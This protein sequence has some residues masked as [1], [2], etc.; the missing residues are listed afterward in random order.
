MKKTLVALLAVAAAWGCTHEEPV[1]PVPSND[2]Y[3]SVSTPDDDA[4]VPG[5]I[6][7]KLTDDAEA[8]RTGVFT[9]GAV[10]SGNEK[11][12]EIA[13]Q[14]GATEIRRV[15]RDG[16]KYA[17]RRRKY[18]LHLWYD[19]KLGEDV[20]VSRAEAGMRALPGVRYAIPLY[21]LVSDEASIV[22]EMAVELRYQPVMTTAIDAVRP[23]VEPPFNDEY[24]D[25]QWHYYNTGTIEGT[26]EGADV[27]LYAA[28]EEE[29]GDPSVIVAV[30]D[31]G[32]DVDH[33]DLAAN[34]WINPG[35][36]PGNGIDDDGNGYVDDVYGYNFVSDSGDIVDY[37]HGTHVA[38]TIA[39]V[40]NNGVGVCGVAGGTG[41]GDGARIMSV[42]W[43]ANND[44]AIP[45]IDRFAYAA[46]NGAVIASCSWE[47]ASPD[48]APDLL[49]GL[50]YFIDM[51]GMDEAGVSQVGPVKGGVVIFA[52]GNSNKNDLAYPVY[53]DRVVSVAAMAAN[54]AKTSY[55][56]YSPKVSILAPGGEDS[57]Q[58]LGIYSTFAD[59][60]YG[61]K[62]GT[63]MATP[64][65]SG[66][67]ALIASKYGGMGF[68]ADQLK[69]K[70]LASVRPISPVVEEQYANQI[71]VGLVDAGMAV[72][73]MSNPQ[74][75][76]AALEEYGVM[77]RPD[78]LVIYCKVPA[79]GNGMPVTKYLLQYAEKKDGVTGEWHDM[80]LI[81][82]EDVGQ[83]YEYGFELV[84]LTTYALKMKAVDRW[85]NEGEEVSFEGTT[86]KHT[87]RPPVQ[88]ARLLDL[89]IASA[90]E[91]NIKRFRMENYFSDPDVAYG[92]ALSFT[93]TSSDPSV[94]EATIDAESVL[95]ILPLKA[96][97]SIITVR[98]LDTEG[99]YL[100][101]SFDVTVESG[102]WNH[103]P[104]VTKELGAVE[105]ERVGDQLT[106]A[107]SE[108]FSD[109]DIEAGDKL[110]YRILATEGNAVE[111][112]ISGDQLV[113]RAVNRG[114]GSL[115]VVATDSS[116]ATAQS[117]LSVTVKNGAGDAAQLTIA[118]NPVADE[119]NISY[120]AIAD[121][122]ANVTI[123]DNAARR[124]KSGAVE[125]RSGNATFNV[126]DL[127][128]GSYTCVVK[129]S[130]GQVSASFIK[131]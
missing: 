63:S 20:P 92:D 66:I 26:A 49:D 78:S 38:G 41:A 60:K 127:R 56:N 4:I 87:N 129:G 98:A 28:W 40:N 50:D 122:I 68:T 70:L 125:F 2:D 8:L 35:E 34:M 45:N 44:I 74:V 5:W 36:I 29:A 18:G 67:A 19:I 91:N 100:D 58:N 15:F 121:E 6:R 120:A 76:P 57:P 79:D 93:A 88:K 32:I 24:L 83:T 23:V 7:I 16:G 116:D 46:D 99:A 47:V 51:A 73:D 94:V 42:Q 110:T 106:F 113:V 126:G 109:A 10:N 72:S 27:N 86:L 3:M 52:A 37:D 96:G 97:T 22:P 90:G 85:G 114:A 39:A 103:A 31:S 53:Y 115:T 43:N 104:E 25:L 75:A 81:N 118:P 101:V 128:P 12:D 130:K 62:N 131:R 9:R 123:Y 107:L 65:V 54:Y 124:V 11:L 33:P 64:H 17:E 21:R 89:T 112:R 61:Y 84:Q 55:S 59:G 108:Y 1:A 82:T 111:G 71:G 14:L 102:Y 117:V 77:G 80:T 95:T 13:Q 105:M 69:E 119:L 48:V 30:L